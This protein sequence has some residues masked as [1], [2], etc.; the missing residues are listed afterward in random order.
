MFNV[1]DF[2]HPSDLVC[3]EATDEALDHRHFQYFDKDGFELNTAEQ[4]FYRANNIHIDAGFLH[5]PAWM[6]NWLMQ[7]DNPLWGT[8][9]FLD[10]SFTCYRCCY[11]GKARDHIEGYAEHHPPARQLLQIRPKW[12]FD[13]DLN[14]VA[15]TGEIFEV[16]HI[17]YDTYTYK[18][19]NEVRNRVTDQLLNIDWESAA[20]E[21]WHRRDEW[22]LLKGYKQND[23]KANLLLGWEY[24]EYI[25][26]VFRL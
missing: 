3:T 9:F 7:D 10:H 26:K 15:D 25:E 11:R 19:F 22:N 12:G 6:D 16:L 14:A 2:I 8:K 5:K 18:D 23:W 24:S 13:I 20:D 1:H 4:L 17:E 21:I